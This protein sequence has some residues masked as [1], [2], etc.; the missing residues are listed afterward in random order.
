MTAGTRFR[1]WF[2]AQ[3]LALR[4]LLAINV[5]LYLLWNLP[6]RY[7]GPVNFFFYEY[8]ALHPVFPDLLVRPWQL[9]TYNFL[10]LGPGLGGLLHVGFNMLWLIW[11]GRDFEETHGADRHLAVYLLAGVGGGLLSL[12]LNSFFPASGLFGGPIVGASAS[13]LGV[14]SCVAFLYPQKRIGLLF[15]G[16]IRLIHLVAAFLILDV[17]FMAGSS[18]AVGAHLGGVLT[19]FVLAR[20]LSAGVD[21]F[22]WSGMFLKRR[23]REGAERRTESSGS[24]L[25][26][27][28]SRLAG[29]GASAAKSRPSARVHTLDVDASRGRQERTKD[30]PDVDRILDKISEQGYYALTDDEKRVL[31]EASQK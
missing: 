30:E 12:L 13:V 4:G 23:S 5:V 19:G 27:L 1:I 2:A 10:H 8:L 7:I 16:P 28:E 18:T 26:R 15:V 9:L 31:Y 25:E 11:V 29:K 14:V 17:L 22:S 24:F 6:L 20:A 3:P 21:V